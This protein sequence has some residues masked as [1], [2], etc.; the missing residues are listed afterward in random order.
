MSSV[1]TAPEVAR[2]SKRPRTYATGPE[3]Y[4]LVRLTSDPCVRWYR[5]VGNHCADLYDVLR[6]R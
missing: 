2:A 4:E 3:V 6:K 5:N 1:A